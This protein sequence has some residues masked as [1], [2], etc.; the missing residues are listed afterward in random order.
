MGFMFAIV[1]RICEAPYFQS[2]AEAA[3]NPELCD[4]F[5]T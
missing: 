3:Y 5:Y 1:V 4:R 2:E